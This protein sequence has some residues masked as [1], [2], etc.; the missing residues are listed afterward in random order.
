MWLCAN[1]R[2]PGVP[3]AIAWPAPQANQSSP[4]ELRSVEPS[5]A[6]PGNPKAS[7]SVP[8]GT[9]D[10]RSP[11]HQLLIPTSRHRYTFSLS[12]IEKIRIVRL[13]TCP[14]QYAVS[15]TFCVKSPPSAEAESDAVV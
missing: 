13:S 15:P 10:E 2:V 4:R 14:A 12:F 6:F 7:Q 3:A 11:L 1:R 8:P 9:L 5:T